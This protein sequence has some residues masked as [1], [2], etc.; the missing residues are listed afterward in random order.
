MSPY[1]III[2]P[3]ITERTVALSYGN[4]SLPE[5]QVVRK[6]TFV[7]HPDANKIQ[8]KQ[9]IE[10]IYNGGKKKKDEK[11]AVASVRTVVMK[12]KSRRV[13]YKNRGSRPDWKKAIITLA[14]GQRL[15][16]YGV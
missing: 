11:I 1:E 7:V 3:H 8:I 16:D 2:K 10:E 5:E 15:E 12:G 14:K 13:G 9:A 6:Y 4:G